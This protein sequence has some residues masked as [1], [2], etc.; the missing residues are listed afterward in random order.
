MF[1]LGYKM[2]AYTETRISVHFSNM[3]PFAKR[4][5]LFVINLY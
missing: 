2:F 3:K 1:T 5:A 4:L